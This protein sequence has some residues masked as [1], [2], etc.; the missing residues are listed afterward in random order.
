MTQDRAQRHAPRGDTDGG[1]AVAVTPRPSRVDGMLDLLAVPQGE[2]WARVE[3]AIRRLDDERGRS[4]RLKLLLPDTPE[5]AS[6]LPRLVARLGDAGLAHDSVR[7]PGGAQS[8]VVAPRAPAAVPAAA[9]QP[10]AR[11]TPATPDA[12]AVAPR[13]VA[14]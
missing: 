7:E 10:P 11:A 2:R 14:A 6:A 1:P 9:P 12:P 3:G 8:M 5:E 13:P 4:W